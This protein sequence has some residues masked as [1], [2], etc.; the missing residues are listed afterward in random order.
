[1]PLRW[2][3]MF[4]RW[5][6]GV[7]QRNAM[8][9]FDHLLEVPSNVSS[10]NKSHFFAI[11]SLDNMQYNVIQWRGW[12]D[13]TVRGKS[14]SHYYQVSRR[15]GAAGKRWRRTFG[16]TLGEEGEGKGGFKIFEFLVGSPEIALGFLSFVGAW[17][18]THLRNNIF[19]WQFVM[20]KLWPDSHNRKFNNQIYSQYYYYYCYI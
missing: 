11:H 13:Y 2:L 18:I 16:Y 10:A 3:V 1:M 14:G 17:K 8:A 5:W 12:R 20:S 7:R 4:C 15:R 19:M 9:N 6:V